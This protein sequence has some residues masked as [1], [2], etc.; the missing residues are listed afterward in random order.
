MLPPEYLQQVADDAERL[1]IRLNQTIT[2]DICRRIVKT[3]AITESAQWQIKMLQESGG[4]MQD[5]IASVSHETGISEAAIS[6]MFVD[7]GIASMRYDAA[8][9][10]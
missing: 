1:Y 9:L 4:L 10:Q 2:N 7:A 6:K 5:I 8:P 3:G